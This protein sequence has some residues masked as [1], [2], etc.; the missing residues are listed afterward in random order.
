MGGQNLPEAPGPEELTAEALTRRLRGLQTQDSVDTP[1]TSSWNTVEQSSQNRT[2][3]KFKTNV[4]EPELHRQES[5]AGATTITADIHSPSTEKANGGLLL[6]QPEVVKKKVSLFDA[7]SITPL[8]EE[9]SSQKKKKKLSKKSKKEKRTEVSKASEN[10]GVDKS[11]ID[12]ERKIQE[13]YVKVP[14]RKSEK[15][16]ENVKSLMPSSIEEKSK[17]KKKSLSFKRSNSSKP[18][19]DLDTMWRQEEE[20]ALGLVKGKGYSP[21]KP[22]F[23]PRG[24]TINTSD[25]N[26]S[27]PSENLSDEET[28]L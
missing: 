11:L 8:K 7:D 25:G 12:L 6:V 17:I 5:G 9:E 13:E 14:E 27:P 10:K 26:S 24:I 18:A 23:Q 28:Y 4:D 19:L 16:G 1:S 22:E 21:V 20:K 3:V 15:E 2:A